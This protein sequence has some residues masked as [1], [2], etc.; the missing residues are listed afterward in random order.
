MGW[1][2][3]VVT[4]ATAEDTELTPVG[5]VAYNEMQPNALYNDKIIIAP[6]GKYTSEDRELIQK[7]FNHMDYFDDPVWF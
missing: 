5:Y 2:L 6:D 4:S 1:D 7:V 3:I